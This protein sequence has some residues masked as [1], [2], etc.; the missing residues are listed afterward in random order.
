MDN[1]LTYT[2]GLLRVLAIYI[3]IK[4]I[5]VTCWVLGLVSKIKTKIGAR[6]YGIDN[7]LNIIKIRKSV[8][9]SRL[10]S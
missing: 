6:C 9:I 7:W 5:E 3:T 10:L 1:S 2:K 8:C 4:L